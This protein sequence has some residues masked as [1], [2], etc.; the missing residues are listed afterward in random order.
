[1][2]D[3]ILKRAREL[4]LRH[5][6]LS[7]WYKAVTVMV[8]FV[9]FS[10]TYALI[11]PALTMER[12][13]FCGLETHAHAEECYTD[14]VLTCGLEEHTHT[15][16]CYTEPTDEEP[17]SPGAEEA[18]EPGAEE[19]EEPGED[20]LLPGDDMSLP[21]IPAPT[22]EPAQPDEDDG[23]MPIAAGSWTQV[24]ST[25]FDESKTYALVVG[26]K[27]VKANTNTALSSDKTIENID[28]TNDKAY[29]WTIKKS[30][31][32]YSI[33]NNG[34]NQYIVLQ[35][36]QGWN[37][38][39]S[40]LGNSEKVLTLGGSNPFS[41]YWVENN[42]NYYYLDGG[43]GV[44]T[45]YS[46]NISPN[47]TIYEW[48]GTTTPTCNC[49]VVGCTCE[50]S[51]DSCDKC[52][53]E[54]CIEA[55]KSTDPD[56]GCNCGKNGCTCDGTC[57]CTSGN[58]NCPGCGNTGGN[59]GGGTGGNPDEDPTKDWPKFTYENLYTFVPSF[60]MNCEMGNINGRP[61]Q[62]NHN[63]W[64]ANV[65]TVLD[66]VDPVTGGLG[67]AWDWRYVANDNGVIDGTKVEV[68]FIDSWWMDNYSNNTNNVGGGQGYKYQHATAPHSDNRNV[69]MVTYDGTKWNGTIGTFTWHVNHT[70]DVLPPATD[71]VKDLHL[72]K[73]LD[74]VRNSG[75]TKFEIG[76]TIYWTV[77]V[78]ND[79][80]H[81]L[82]VDVN[83]TLPGAQ[84]LDYATLKA[85][86]NPMFVPPNSTLTLTARYVVTSS[87]P[88]LNNILTNTVTGTNKGLEGKDSTPLTPA[89]STAEIDSTPQY[90]FTLHYDNGDAPDEG[91]EAVSVPDDQTSGTITQ[92]EWQTKVSE[93]VPE[94]PG[95][96][97]LYWVDENGIEYDPGDDIIL[98]ENKTL[99]AVWSEDG[100]DK[101][102]FTLVFDPGAAKDDSTLDNMPDKPGGEDVAEYAW[103]RH[104]DI[105]ESG[106]TD[107][108]L[109]QF[110]AYER[111]VPTRNG[112]IFKGW[113]VTG[114]GTVD[115]YEDGDIPVKDL[116]TG[117]I[118]SVT[119]SVADAAN[120]EDKTTVFALND[121]GTEN[122]NHVIK[123]ITAIW[124]RAAVINISKKWDDPS[125][126][127]EVKFELWV[128][129]NGLSRHLGTI[130]M[131]GSP[132][133]FIPELDEDGNPTGGYWTDDAGTGTP[134][135]TETGEW[136]S[137]FYYYLPDN[138]SRATVYIY[139]ATTGFYQ[140][141]SGDAE[142]VYN[143]DPDG[144]GSDYVDIAAKITVRA[145]EYNVTVT[146]YLFVPITVEKIW[147]DGKDH[148]ETI[149]VPIVRNSLNDNAYTTVGT[150]TLTAA[151]AKIVNGKTVWTKTFNYAPRN[152]TKG[153][154]LY[155]Y[156][157]LDGVASYYPIYA[158]SGA[159]GTCTSGTYNTGDGNRDAVLITPVKPGD[160]GY[161]V[162]ITNY[163]TVDVNV[164][165]V[166]FGKEPDPSVSI[167]VYVYRPKAGGGYEW[168]DTLTLKSGNQ[169]KTVLEG[170]KV[171]DI[172]NGDVL[173]IY[174]RKLNEYYPLY[175]SGDD[176]TTVETGQ[177]NPNNNGLVNA[178]MIT[179]KPDGTY[180]VTIT[181]MPN[182]KMPDTGG[183][184][185]EVYTFTGALLALLAVAGL[186]YMKRGQERGS[187]PRPTR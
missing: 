55:N 146:N 124:T 59:Q 103:D 45:Q 72:N 22:E 180:T 82:W 115:F 130:T 25:S 63:Q 173:Y 100:A 86:S 92:N 127:Q 34:N 71:T 47:V 138:S 106:S 162:T 46:S 17:E 98:T 65:K 70:D 187:A 141:Y 31:N 164:E 105:P 29:T 145:D 121:D 99:T 50:T 110:F 160:S 136:S 152:D 155:V 42:R 83:D 61:P 4:N 10:T 85:V 84:L 125:M 43:L 176:D 172:V 156:E 131:N 88:T 23:I 90:E 119:V 77:T 32:G 147:A 89:S 113:D 128:V 117:K 150:V 171:K 74:S 37:S 26:G 132:D 109:T 184:G 81:G 40:V 8:A 129:E 5:G 107:D 9:V 161:T 60:T 54:A 167:A 7:K 15:E 56:T 78:R 177:F 28:G 144:D 95:H 104:L 80:A 140:V 169:W 69:F 27:A 116:V 36:G 159:S 30:G 178:A 53:C 68:Y 16:D 158:A 101:I 20:A 24:T 1:M 62:P 102:R 135:G 35:P 118:E 126:A 142:S 139:E 174:E 170:Y 49:D 120:S 21:A 97:F 134:D 163:N 183:M 57:G 108:M 133:R 175:S 122:T 148:E 64:N 166:W 179:V 79:N 11:M 93:T 114:D 2:W 137:A 67:I 6:R 91:D 76:D 58:C 157:D 38:S 94:W 41:L 168:V 87:S 111:T 12:D 165:K 149:T 153:A 186:M 181:N 44:S 123:T 96:T 143:V 182:T 112:W 3:E 185:R 14:G 52:D 18:E 154:N 13:A 48:T 73:A 151:D 75:K 33:R 51:H 39:G 19:T 66:K